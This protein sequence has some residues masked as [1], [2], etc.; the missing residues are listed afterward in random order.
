MESTKRMS[1]HTVCCVSFDLSVY[2]I[3]MMLVG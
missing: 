3:Q 1:A 2:I